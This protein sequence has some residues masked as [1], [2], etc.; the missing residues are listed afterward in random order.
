MF[1]CILSVVE[2]R[3]RG[4]WSVKLIF[5]M[6]TVS[7]FRGRSVRRCTSSLPPDQETPQEQDISRF[8]CRV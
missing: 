3:A 2:K 5:G 7:R 4:T 1:H 6:V 8:R